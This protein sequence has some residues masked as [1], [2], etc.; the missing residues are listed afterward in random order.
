[1]AD[2]IA[3]SDSLNRTMQ[4]GNP[5]F[6]PIFCAAAFRLNRTMQYGNINW[7]TNIAKAIKCLNRTMQYGNENTAGEVVGDADTV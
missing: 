3:W 1:M 5:I 4:Y 7:I 2:D 6:F